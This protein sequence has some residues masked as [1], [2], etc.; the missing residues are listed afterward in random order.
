MCWRLLLVLVLLFFPG[1]GAAGQ[2]LVTSGEHDGFSRLAITLD[3]PRAWTLGRTTDGYELR[4]EGGAIDFDL[5]RAFARIPKSRLGD[6][7][8]D[9]DGATLR[10]A[11]TCACHARPF[12]F[13]DNIVVVDLRDGPPPAGSVYEAMLEPLKPAPKP[14]TTMQPTTIG[15]YDWTRPESP[16]PQPPAAVSLSSGLDTAILADNL[17][18]ELGAAASAGVIELA[19]PAPPPKSE[20]VVPNEALPNLRILDEPGVQAR[21]GG[22][23]DE[24]EPRIAETCIPEAELALHEWGG[25]L[26]PLEVLATTRSSILDGTD[27]PDPAAVA[28]AAR[29][30]I[31]IGFG[32]EALQLL[33]AMGQGVPAQDMLKDLAVII[34]GGTTQP[35]VFA[36]MENCNSPAALWSVLARPSLRKAEKINSGAITRAFSALPL[37]LRQALAQGLGERLIQQGDLEAARIVESAVGRA[38]QE[39]DA[40]LKLL[41]GQR[42]L[43]SGAP[44]EAVV[45]LQDVADEGGPKS[46]E[47]LVKLVDLAVRDQASIDAL[48][49]EAL[50]VLAHENADQP[51]YQDLRR[52]ILLAKALL[53][54]FQGA[55]VDLDAVPEVEAQLWTMLAEQGPDSALLE[56]ATLRSGDPAPKVAAETAIRIAE[57]FIDL[58]LPGQVPHWVPDGIDL[59]DEQRLVRAKALLAL[60]DARAALREV[61]GLQ[62]NEAREIEARAFSQLGDTTQAALAFNDNG[63]DDAVQQMRRISRDWT[64][65]SQTQGVW[66]QAAIMAGEG[67]PLN[68]APPDKALALSEALL[69]D[70]ISA[71][72]A[73]D[74]LLGEVALPLPSP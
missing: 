31:H 11:L 57:R 29:S 70:S 17:A 52:A 68:A 59:P 30:L 9:R 5:S 36:G 20:P 62:G 58:G 32:Q 44:D 43:A 7:S 74:S 46:A 50:E 40:S 73:V 22:Q 55:F 33:D 24:A 23:L 13:R 53:S 49:L 19:V 35:S 64:S 48:T 71:R 69:K 66:G 27:R 26:S 41:S 4:F 38:V 61:A 1:I 10:F 37:S 60:R 18:R 42:K 63:D 2:A 47:A 25:G 72:N 3:A 28:A 15:I 67:P 8:A 65:V 45:L 12:E 51:I 16:K 6:V 14:N 21:L 54:D 34:D 39:P 56:H